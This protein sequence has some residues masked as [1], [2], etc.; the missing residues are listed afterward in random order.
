MKEQYI[1]E[2]ENE[3]EEQNKLLA[4]DSQNPHRRG[5][6]MGLEY[7]IEV[8]KNTYNINDNIEA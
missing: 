2:L 5:L 8:I 6:I 3:I 4:D 1:L 7:A